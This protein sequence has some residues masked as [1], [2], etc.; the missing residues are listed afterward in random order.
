MNDEVWSYI[1]VGGPEPK[2]SKIPKQLL[3]KMRTELE[4]FYPLDLRTSAKDLINNHLTFFIYNHVAI[5]PKRHWPRG[6]RV[7]GYLLL[8]NEKMSK[9]T[10]NFMNMCD[11]LERYGAD[12]TRFALADSG[13]GLD[14][15]NFVEKTADDAVLKLY[16]EL[17]WLR[18][19]L[20]DENLRT[21]EYNW[22]DKVLDAELNLL[23]EQARKAYDNM[24]YREVL[25]V[26]FYDLQNA[27]NEYR[28]VTTGQ[29]LGLDNE[30]WAGLHH[31]MVVK[32][33]ELQALL[34]S[35]ITPHWSDYIWREILK[36][37]AT[38]IKERFP[39][40]QSVDESVI[41]ASNYIRSLTT[42]IRATEELANKRKKKKQAVD[43]IQGPQK[44]ELYVADKF[45][46]WQTQAIEVLKETWTAAKGF[47]D[48]EVQK[49]KERGLLKNKK[50]MPFVAIIKKNASEKGPS[51]FDRN[52][53]FDE[54]QVLDQNLD[55]LRRE[56]VKL[57]ISKVIVRNAGECEDAAKKEKVEAASEPGQPAF[58]TVADN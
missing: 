2:D 16:T 51:A 13:D 40:S 28:K 49:L 4:Y 10:G 6:V 44:L 54:H 37:P 38:I 23:V 32:F 19:T 36:K 17:E 39:T 29:G 20:N 42:H 50:I 45:P 53:L 18:E 55:L 27:R 30:N 33:A 8:N 25:K 3:E 14:D 15:A 26:A 35:P 9:S 52:L 21:G 41:A 34:M 7:N 47:D 57:K 1:M 5:F 58:F 31:D 11:S 12:A 46:D 48:T 56:L 24:L 22:N 43:E